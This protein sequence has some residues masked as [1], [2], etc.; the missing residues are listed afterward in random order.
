L[1]RTR[2][3]S[4][5]LAALKMGGGG[6]RGEIGGGQ[7]EGGRRAVKGEEGKGVMVGG[8]EKEGGVG[9]GERRAT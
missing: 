1:V 4:Y 3:K 2:T 5:T 7:K 6:V 9:E 8:G